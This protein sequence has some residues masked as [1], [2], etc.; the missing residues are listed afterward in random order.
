MPC[1]GHCRA[2]NS[3][4]SPVIAR[5]DLD[6]YR[7]KGPD[8]TT[9]LIIDGLRV[10]GLPNGT[11]LDI[12]GGIG[13]LHHEL[14]DSSLTAAVHVEAS[15]AYLETG[16]S[17]SERC[18]V[19]DRVEFVHGDFVDLASTLGEAD[20]VTLDRVV[21][22]YPKYMPLVE[23]AAGKARRLFAL[24]LPKDVWYVRM[25]MGLENLIRRLRGNAFRTFVHSAD[26][27]DRFVKGLG[28]A[29]V[30]TSNTLTWSVTVYERGAPRVNA[31]ASHG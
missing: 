12:G 21:C 15:A 25:V 26:A 31:R 30:A 10:A 29:S 22:C 16:K 8:K 19:G 18:G 5:R 2:A 4:F 6:R 17:E 7:R 14:L 28:F 20:V 1:S 27:I 13:V 3:Q 24:S 23:R 11:L 9:Q